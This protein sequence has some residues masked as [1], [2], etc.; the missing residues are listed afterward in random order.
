MIK[1]LN[2]QSN[3]IVFIIA[4]V[5]GIAIALQIKTNNATSVSISRDLSELQNNVRSYAEKNRELNDRNE[6][7]YAEIEKLRSNEL[8]GDASFQEIVNEKEKYKT[9]A[10][11]TE[12]QNTG[13]TIDMKIVGQGQMNDSTIRIVVNELNAVGAQAI[14]INDQRKVATTEIR[15]SGE[16]MIINGVGFPRVGNF[17]IKAIINADELEYA[18][19]MLNTLKNT[20]LEQMPLEQKIE[21]T[22]KVEENIIIAALSE[23]SI[24]YKT[25]LLMPVNTDEEKVE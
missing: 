4:I 7:L 12:V 14:S 13:L 9:F 11:M 21:M 20:L 25:D 3:L 17:K 15:S 23:D 22:I 24:A 18:A 5:L 1:K 16:N 6:A 2:L 19:S 10:G 8:E